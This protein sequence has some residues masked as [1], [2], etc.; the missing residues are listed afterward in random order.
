MTDN[1]DP[2][3]NL[4]IEPGENEFIALKR[5]LGNEADTLILPTK[6]Q[7]GGVIQRKPKLPSDVQLYV[8]L[9][10]IAGLFI[11]FRFTQKGS[12]G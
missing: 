9:L 6:P 1:F 3:V 12:V 10:T 4:V 2:F 7:L 8:G 5:S 11:V